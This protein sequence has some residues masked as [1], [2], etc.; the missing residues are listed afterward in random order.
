MHVKPAKKLAHMHLNS[1]TE[2][3]ASI[4]VDTNTTRKNEFRDDK[5]VSFDDTTV[6]SLQKMHFL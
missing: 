1:V 5:R 6:K 2:T 4:G 3:D